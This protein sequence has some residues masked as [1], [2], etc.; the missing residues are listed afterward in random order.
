M[1]KLYVDRVEYAEALKAEAKRLE[2][3]RLDSEAKGV[4]RSME[5]LRNIP[6]REISS[7]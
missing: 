5:I 1:S 7:D 3:L 6:V 2:H 4:R